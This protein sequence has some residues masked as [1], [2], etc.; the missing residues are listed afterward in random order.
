MYNHSLSG[1]S[2]PPV[3]RSYIPPL[4]VLHCMKTPYNLLEASI[5][6]IRVFSKLSAAFGKH[7]H[8]GRFAEPVSIAVLFG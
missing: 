3:H 4:P 6:A 2:L 7:L 8:N 1:G 5:L